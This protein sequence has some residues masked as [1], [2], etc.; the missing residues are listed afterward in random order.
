MHIPRFRRRQIADRVPQLP[1]CGRSE[2]VR[3]VAKRPMAPSLGSYARSPRRLRHP[4]NSQ[5]MPSPSPRT[6]ETAAK[7]ASSA[8]CCLSQL[9]SRIAP[10]RSTPV[11][12]VKMPVLSSQPLDRSVEISRKRLTVLL[13]PSF[14][15]PGVPEQ[16]NSSQFM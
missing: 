8:Q 1:P 14:D 15:V 16:G 7:V 3:R 2:D 10:V 13:G 9:Q 5:M 11:P 12:L 4:S 6:I